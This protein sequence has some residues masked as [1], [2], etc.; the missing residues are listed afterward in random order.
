MLVRFF[1]ESRVAIGVH[2]IQQFARGE[3]MP[4]DSFIVGD[5]YY[6]R[7]LRDSRPKLFLLRV[8]HEDAGAIGLQHLAR[9]SNDYFQGL[10]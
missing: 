8:I 3:Y 6:L 4:C 1:I 2:Y 9:I 5:S 10:L 7:A